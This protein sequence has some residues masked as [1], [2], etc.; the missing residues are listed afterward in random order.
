MLLLLRLLCPSATAA[1]RPG[2]TSGVG[3]PA[4]WACN[5]SDSQTE[6]H[7]GDCWPILPMQILTHSPIKNSPRHN[8]AGLE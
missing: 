4:N 8:Q 5:E 6:V 7:K 1:L 3:R 2:T